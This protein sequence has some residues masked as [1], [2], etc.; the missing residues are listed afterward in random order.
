MRNIIANVWIV[1]IAILH[2]IPG[3]DVQKI[4]ISELLLIDKLAHII[5]FMIGVYLYA[6]AGKP[7]QKAQFLRNISVLFIIY[8]LLLEVLQSFIFVSRSADFLDWLADIIGV[9]LGIWIYK[10]IPLNVS[11]NSFKKD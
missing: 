1:F 7:Q 9:F 8:G 4:I 6:I 2:A 3:A 11:T 5:I 10:K